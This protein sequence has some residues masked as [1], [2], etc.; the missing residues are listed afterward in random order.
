MNRDSFIFYKDWKEAIKDLPDDI[1][2]EIYESVIEYA[3]SGNIKGLKPMA[4]IA[5]NFIKTNIDRDAERYMS[6]VERNRENGKNG[7]RPKKTGNKPKKPIGFNENPNKPKKPDNDND[8]DLKEKEI[9]TSN[10]D[11][12]LKKEKNQN[13]EIEK[14]FN[15][16]QKWISENAPNVSKMKEPFTINEF[17]KI[18]S[19]FDMDTITETILNMHNW[20]PL[21]TKNLNANLTFR[22]W[23]EKENK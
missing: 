19:E 14:R 2:L 6:I 15:D 9:I 7:G 23:I 20:K 18:I 21:L 8:N 5:F 4:N 12:N 11:N 3:T 10:E 22:R 13:S 1:R 16:F 17:E